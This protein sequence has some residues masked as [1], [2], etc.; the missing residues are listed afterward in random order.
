MHLYQTGDWE[1]AARHFREADAEHHAPAIVY[2]L[3]LSEEKLGHPQAAV[4][5]Y[6]IADHH[7]DD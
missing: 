1:G 4:D 5:A 2:N 7:T 6:E 3:G